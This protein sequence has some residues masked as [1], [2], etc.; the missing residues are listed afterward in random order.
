MHLFTRK[1]TDNKFNVGR[2][3]RLGF[4]RCGLFFGT[5]KIAPFKN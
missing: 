1:T 2:P 3:T 4:L 5:L